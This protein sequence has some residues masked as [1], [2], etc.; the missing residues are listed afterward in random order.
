MLRRS[1]ASIGDTAGRMTIINLNTTTILNLAAND[2][3]QVF[4]LNY[5]GA[6]SSFAYYRGS[7]FFEGYL[8]G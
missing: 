5:S 2:F 1:D 8:I 4:G 3:V 6:G 7:S